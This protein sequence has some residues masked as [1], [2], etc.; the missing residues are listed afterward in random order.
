MVRSQV[1]GEV[2]PES[3]A[4]QCET[5]STLSFSLI[6]KARLPYQG[7]NTLS[8]MAPN[9]SEGSGG[10][11]SSWLVPE[12]GRVWY[13]GS[14]RLLW[15][16]SLP[17]ST[18]LLSVL[19]CGSNLDG[20]DGIVPSVLKGMGDEAA[21]GTGRAWWGESAKSMLE[22]GDGKYFQRNWMN[23]IVGK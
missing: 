9:D 12:R 11:W 7:E 22:D 16:G 21:R 2:A 10:T 20:E 3:T 14:L 17:D 15:T 6:R 5:W 1:M 19:D 4:C 13:V 8:M 18:L 23:S